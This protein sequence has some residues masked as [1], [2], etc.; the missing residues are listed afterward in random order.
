MQYSACFPVC[1]DT[2]KRPLLEDGSTHFGKPMVTPIPLPLYIAYTSYHGMFKNNP[3]HLFFEEQGLFLSKVR[4][5]TRVHVQQCILEFVLCNA[6]VFLF[7]VL[8]YILYH[9]LVLGT[10][11]CMVMSNE[12]ALE[13]QY[14]GGGEGGLVQ[15]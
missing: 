4:P 5:Q 11:M 1:Q 14:L 3:T 2:P 13:R 15:P 10:C 7:P 6:T 12:K 9:M 8:F